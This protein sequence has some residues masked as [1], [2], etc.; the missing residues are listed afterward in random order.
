MYRLR[1]SSRSA[2]ERNAFDHLLLDP[3]GV[4]Q[5]IEFG[6][7]QCSQ[8]CIGNGRIDTVGPDVLAG[9]L[10]FLGTQVIAYILAAPL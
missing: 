3:A 5:G 4:R 6:R 1:S 9:R 7:R 10:A 8:E 2:L